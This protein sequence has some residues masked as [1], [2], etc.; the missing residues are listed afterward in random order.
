MS[1]TTKCAVPRQIK[2]RN[3]EFSIRSTVFSFV[4]CEEKDYYRVVT[5]VQLGL[6]AARTAS[7]AFVGVKQIIFSHF[8][9]G[10][11]SR[12]RLG[13]TKLTVSF[14]ASY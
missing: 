11:E 3:L 6:S 10:F 1:F 4:S 7:T 9:S 13:E 14:G 5:V 2:P 8:F 12:P